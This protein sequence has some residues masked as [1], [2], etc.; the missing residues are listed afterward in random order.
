MQ[1]SG[2][3][4]AGRSEGLASGVRSGG[5]EN[6]EFSWNEKSRGARPASGPISE[7]GAIGGVSREWHRAL[8]MATLGSAASKVDYQLLAG[9][10]KRACRRWR[11]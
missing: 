6:A 11:L 7:G 4:A 8:A 5:G 1:R 10:A 2:V 3:S 9:A